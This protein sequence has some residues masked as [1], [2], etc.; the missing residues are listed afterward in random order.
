MLQRVHACVKFGLKLKP[1][2][3]AI[4]NIG[5]VLQGRSLPDQARAARQNQGNQFS[6]ITESGSRYR[7]FGLGSRVQSARSR[8]DEMA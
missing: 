4:F 1:A 3:A 6:V 2:D 7:S 8:L 5:L